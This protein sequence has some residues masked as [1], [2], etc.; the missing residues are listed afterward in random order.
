MDCDAVF[1]CEYLYVPL[2]AALDNCALPVSAGNKIAAVSNLSGELR[3]YLL[4][5]RQEPTTLSAPLPARA[6][7]NLVE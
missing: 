6:S 1:H 2:L 4:P 3:D 7:Q 5:M